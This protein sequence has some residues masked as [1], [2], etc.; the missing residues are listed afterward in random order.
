MI[1]HNLTKLAFVWEYKNRQE[2]IKI[3]SECGG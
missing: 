2:K 1:L 3:C